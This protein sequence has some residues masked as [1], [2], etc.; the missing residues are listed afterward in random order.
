MS[1]YSFALNDSSN[2]TAREPRWDECVNL[3]E[4]FPRYRIQWE[5]D[6]VT[7]PNWPPA[8]W[9]WLMEIPCRHGLI[10][11]HGRTTLTAVV[12]STRIARHVAKLPCIQRT[13]GGPSEMRVRFDVAD[14][15]QVFALMRPRRKRRA[16][17]ADHIGQ[18]RF[19]KAKRDAYRRGSEGVNG[20]QRNR[21]TPR[22]S[23]ALQA[24]RSLREG[25]AS[26]LVVR[27]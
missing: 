18:H 10:H 26:S 27:R 1:V 22:P 15:E 5:A 16:K 23:L 21:P 25:A 6:G 4:Q 13:T 19:K 12:T 20:P 8:D 11:P 14:A 17:S 3:A 9:P 7:K 24:S 2:E